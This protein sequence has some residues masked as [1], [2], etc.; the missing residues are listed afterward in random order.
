MT[1]PIK[2]A[3][4]EDYPAVAAGEGDT[5]RRFAVL[6]G[7]AGPDRPGSFRASDCVCVVRSRPEAT[8]FLPHP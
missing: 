6:P 7:V 5:Q 4:A 8:R 1:A 3:E 2:E